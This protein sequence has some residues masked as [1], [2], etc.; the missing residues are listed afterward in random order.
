MVTHA[1]LEQ[2]VLLCVL[3]AFIGLAAVFIATAMFTEI[4]HTVDGVEKE[5]PGIFGGKSAMAQV[6]GV[7]NSAFA[8]GCVVGP[9]FAGL[10]KDH[11]GWGTMGWSLGVL[12]AATS[13]P[14]LLFMSGWIGDHK[15]QLEDD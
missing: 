13:V 3:L 12:S 2:E 6:Y 15:A 9:I 10:I 8:T 5:Y 7:S 11:A 1:S 4:A 14:V